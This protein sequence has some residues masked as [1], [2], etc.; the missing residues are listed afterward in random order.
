MQ[1]FGQDY[2]LLSTGVHRRACVHL[3]L[4]KIPAYLP[5]MDIQKILAQLHEERRRVNDAILT[6]ERL[7]QG[8]QRKGTPTATNRRIVE[9]KLTGTA[10]PAARAKSP[11]TEQKV[12][13]K[14]AGN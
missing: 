14:A 8:T 11:K 13:S 12:R 6:L 10:S 3:R 7:T 2:L 5:A 1:N 4:G 9:G